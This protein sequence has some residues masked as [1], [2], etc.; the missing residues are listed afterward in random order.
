MEGHKNQNGGEEWVVDNDPDA[1]IAVL[2]NLN[3]IPMIGLF[4]ETDDLLTED[5][6]QTSTWNEHGVHS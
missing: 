2:W 4:N 6:Y 3:M 1:F 5:S